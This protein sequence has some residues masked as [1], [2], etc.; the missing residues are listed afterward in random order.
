M[1]NLPSLNPKM[2]AKLGEDIYRQKYQS[3]YEAHHLG[4]F[5]AINV[6]NQQATLGES[7]YEAL[8]QAK[9]ADPQG[10]F[11]LIRVGFSSAFQITHAYEYGN[12]GSGPDWIFR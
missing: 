1:T 7:P 12:S 4:K 11:H 9:A 8:E 2:I 10:L 5:V 6:R 3:E